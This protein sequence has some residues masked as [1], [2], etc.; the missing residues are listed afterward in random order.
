MAITWRAVALAAFGVVV[1]LVLPVPGTILVW[2]LLVVALCG[3]D[4]WL[5]IAGSSFEL[6]RS[7]THPWQV[8]V[9]AAAMVWIFVLRRGVVAGLLVF[10]GVGVV[11]ALAGVRV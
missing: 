10:A 8:A 11:I 2:S 9:L 5:A 6:A 3:V 4:V 7:F 1:V